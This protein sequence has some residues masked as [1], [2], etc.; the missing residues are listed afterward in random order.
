[1]R[2][3][4]AG[5]RLAYTR[6]AGGVEVEIAGRPVGTIEGEDFAR[7]LLAVWLGAAPPNPEL[8]TGLLG[9]GCE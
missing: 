1:M 8:K 2:D 6:R 3:V 4:R 5:D 7:A 9:G